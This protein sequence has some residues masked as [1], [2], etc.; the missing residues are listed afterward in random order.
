M[1]ALL[2]A[3]TFAALCAASTPTAP[4]TAHAT[5]AWT[6]PPPRS[7]NGDWEWAMAARPLSATV[8]SD[9]VFSGSHTVTIDRSHAWQ[10]TAPGTVSE[11]V[12]TAVCRRIIADPAKPAGIYY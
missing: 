9:A 1:R 8:D 6:E 10:R 5:V 7:A 12:A 3:A 11:R 4:P 2:F